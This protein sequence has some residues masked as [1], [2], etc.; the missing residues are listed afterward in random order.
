MHRTVGI[1]I[2]I[3]R[4]GNVFGNAYRLPD[5]PF[6][7]LNRFF[8][9]STI[10]NCLVLT[11]ICQMNIFYKTSRICFFLFCFYIHS[12]SHG[13]QILI[14]RNLFSIYRNS[15]LSGHCTERFFYLFFFHGPVC[16]IFHQN[17]ILSFFRIP[18]SLYRL[19]FRSHIRGF[20][21]FKNGDLF[22]FLDRYSVWI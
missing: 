8:F 1:Y 18:E 3:R 20:P 4:L 22:H 10:L 9:C 13:Y 15:G 7:N 19:L 2:F 11:R 17:M 21:F 6:Q 12:C 16:F 14:I 5:H